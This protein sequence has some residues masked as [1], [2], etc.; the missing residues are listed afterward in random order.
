MAALA[1]RRVARWALA[2][3]ALAALLEVFA[4]AAPESLGASVAPALAA[5]ALAAPVLVARSYRSSER[6]LAELQLCSSEP[7]SA[8]QPSRSWEQA[9]G[10]LLRWLERELEVPESAVLESVV[11][12]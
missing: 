10:R 1:R 5:S 11:A 4:S 3:V 6:A 2:L 9:W 12:E 7:A 8:A